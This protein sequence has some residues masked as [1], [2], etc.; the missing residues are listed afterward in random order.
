MRTHSPPETKYKETSHLRLPFKPQIQTPSIA[1]N[2]NNYRGFVTCNP[3]RGQ[4]LSRPSHQTTYA[5]KVVKSKLAA[6]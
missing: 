5:L 3:T 6:M 4:V 1:R 2:V